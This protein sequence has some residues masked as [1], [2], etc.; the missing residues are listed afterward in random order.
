MEAKQSDLIRRLIEEEPNACQYEGI[1]QSV[2]FL[3]QVSDSVVNDALTKR[4]MNG[5][6]MKAVFCL[7]A[8][9]IQATKEG[10]S[11][12]G[13]YKLTEDI[14]K[15]L[16]KMSLMPTNSEDGFVYTATFFSKVAI[17]G[18]D[19]EIVIKAPKRTGSVPY[20]QMQREYF[21]GTLI[22]NLRYTI[23]T[24]LYTLGAFICVKPGTTAT[25]LK[26]FVSDSKPAVRLQKGQTGVVNLVDYGG[27]S[28]VQ[29]DGVPN[30]QTVGARKEQDK[31]IQYQRGG[32]R[33]ICSS[34]KPKK[35]KKLENDVIYIMSEKING[36]TVSHMIRTGELN[37][38]SWLVLFAQLLLTLEVAQRKIG[39][40]HFDLHAGNV[41]AR[42]SER[43]SY[44]INLDGTTYNV[45][46]S[47]HYPVIID[48]GM[49][50]ARTKGVYIGA[51][52]YEGYGML[53]F[54]VPGFDMYKFMAICASVA[55]VESKTSLSSE[56]KKLFSFYDGPK[57]ESRDPYN[58]ANEVDGLSEGRH[59]L[60]QKVTWSDAAKDTPLMMFDWLMEQ[61]KYKKIIETVITPQKRVQLS[62]LRYSNALQ[63]YDRMFKRDAEGRE[64]AINL[65]Q[66]CINGRYSYIL[67]AYFLRILRNYNTELKS[68]IL[69]R[70]IESLESNT[71]EF[72][73]QLIKE[74][75]RRLQTVFAITL[76]KQD[77]LKRAC[78][79]VLSLDIR[80]RNAKSKNDAVEA[81]D[82]LLEYKRQF[83]PYLESYYT[84]LELGQGD[85]KDLLT[86]TAVKSFSKWVLEF[87]KS[88]IYMFYKTNL[89]LV[90]QASRWGQTLI[91]SVPY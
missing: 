29:F 75:M 39:F 43:E 7:F 56:I 53:S 59:E 50:C 33:A 54:M 5:A 61:S 4:H 68:D 21:L 15:W 38:E 25:V 47:K 84:I 77:D 12:S 67:C 17:G 90:E 51:Y 1:E 72:A 63:E 71:R 19:V 9:V 13:L 65:I 37:F 86:E 60:Y 83:A 73:D 45:S 6:D 82:N 74:D 76:P 34:K 64:R 58:I 69:Q 14:Q 32:I 20:L 81:L 22:N 70:S 85:G 27:A 36:N 91:A 10:D 26:D 66:K 57:N 52:L 89:P 8:T 48:F 28:V 55:R 3:G 2:N 42:T 18:S 88:P 41:M 62:Y 16:T 80:T 79:H 35:S 23:P 30:P 49:A 46:P 87:Q 31:F 44:V 11:T 40:T 24:F 78:D